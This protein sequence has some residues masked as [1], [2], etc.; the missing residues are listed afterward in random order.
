MKLNSGEF[1]EGGL[2]FLFQFPHLDFLCSVLELL[3][4]NVRN[5][6]FVCLIL[7]VLNL[8]FY[9]F[10]SLCIFFVVVVALFPG[11]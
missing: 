7:Y 5:P 10:S 3:L 6:G 1:W 4:V 11:R 9:P 2:P 8:P